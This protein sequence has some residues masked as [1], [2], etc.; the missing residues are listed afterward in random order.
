VTRIARDLLESVRRQLRGSGE[1]AGASQAPLSLRVPSDVP[2]EVAAA[3]AERLATLVRH[4]AGELG[5]TGDVSSTVVPAGSREPTAV[6]LGGRPVAVVPVAES[7]RDDWA[8]AVTEATDRALLRRLPLLLGA[9]TADLPSGSTGDREPPD[10]LAAYLLANGVSVARAQAAQD[11]AASGIPAGTCEL[12]ELLIDQR[13]PREVLVQASSATLRQVSGPRPDDLVRA[14]EH[15]FVETGLQFPDVRLSVTDDA[16][17]TVRFRLNDVT[18]TRKL[19]AAAGWSEVVDAL[20]AELTA[21]R[22]WFVRVSDVTQSLDQLEGSMPDLVRLSTRCHS[23][24]LLAACLRA[25][26]RRGGSVRNLPRVLWLLLEVGRETPTDRLT[27]SYRPLLASVGEWEPVP[28]EP[29]LLVAGLLRRVEE[30]SPVL[31]RG[32]SAVPDLRLDPRV[33]DALL[34]AT[35]VAALGAAE[36]EVLAA[37]PTDRPVRLVVGPVRALAAVQAALQ[38]LPNP[39]QVVSLQQLGFADLVR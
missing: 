20:A 17:G 4:R 2:D 36:W 29:D 15:L 3:A 8:E 35:D 14:R 39:P 10:A 22:S 33:E 19:G 25:L 12:G 16:P 34:Q 24:P 30:E 1:D 23:R 21:Y 13:V 6:L 9:G 11:S 32:S 26:L 28:P 27:L 31:P 37:V 38:A 5:L 18:L 7:G